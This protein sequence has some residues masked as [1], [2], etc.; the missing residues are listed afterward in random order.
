MQ[1]FVIL[2]EGCLGG[3]QKSCAEFGPGRIWGRSRDG[4][5]ANTAARA[6]QI[7]GCA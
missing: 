5:I 2:V 4:I 1:W 6:L 7:T 3:L